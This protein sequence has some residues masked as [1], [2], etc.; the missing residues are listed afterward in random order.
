MEDWE[1][2]FVKLY[3][4]KIYQN[5]LIFELSSPKHR[6]RAIS[7]F[8]HNAFSLLNIS[9]VTYQ[10]L[11]DIRSYLYKTIK[12]CEKIHILSLDD[13]DGKC[14]IFQNAFEYCLNSYMVVI[15]VCEHFAIIKEEVTQGTPKMYLLQQT[16]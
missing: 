14:M 1:L 15:L 10:G 6:E 13:N 9:L 5:R 4:K 8:S 12:K 3:V 7:R 11:D 2:N 16:I